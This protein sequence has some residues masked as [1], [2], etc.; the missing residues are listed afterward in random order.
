[1]VRALWVEF[2]VSSRP[3]SEGFSPGSPLFL[4]PQKSTCLNYNSIGIQ[5]KDC[6]VLPSLNEANLSFFYLLPLVKRE[7]VRWF[8]VSAIALE[9][10]VRVRAL[11]RVIALC[12]ILVPSMRCRVSPVF[13]AGHAF[14]NVHQTHVIIS[15][16]N[17]AMP[18]YT[19]KLEHLQTSRKFVKSL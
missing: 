1:V 17:H 11:A 8:V 5:L 16:Y 3:C 7:E 6:Y 2:V 10:A 9:R 4:P 15:K 18:K 19:G 13:L 14:K 12:C